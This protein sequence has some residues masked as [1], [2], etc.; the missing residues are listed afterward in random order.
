MTEAEHPFE[1]YE[2]LDYINRK[3]THVLSDDQ[4]LESIKSNINGN[5]S[6]KPLSFGVTEIVNPMQAYYRR[7][8]PQMP[9]DPDVI[10]KLEYGTDIHN[11][12]FY[13]LRYLDGD[14]IREIDID[15]SANGLDG[16]RGRMDFRMGDS[17][18]EFKTTTHTINTEEDVIIQNPHDI[19]QLATYA[20]VTSVPGQEHHLIYFS[21]DLERFF[22]VFSVRITDS[23]ALSS[24]INRRRE[25]LGK[26]LEV[27]SPELLGKCRYLDTGCKFN[28]SGICKCSSAERIGDSHLRNFIAIKRDLEFEEK[29]QIAR[30]NVSPP[31]TPRLS[32][33][34]LFT[35][36]KAYIRKIGE[37]VQKMPESDRN[38]GLSFHEIESAIKRLP[39]YSGSREMMVNG[40]SLGYSWGIKPQV[41]SVP[42]GPEDGFA[43]VITR[44]S[45]KVPQ[46]IN[47]GSISPH[48]LARLGMVC[49]TTGSRNGYVAMGF[50]NNDHDMKFYKVE[51][52]DVDSIRAEIEKRVD[53]ITQA[54]ESD[55]VSRLPKCPDFVRKNC[56]SNCLCTGN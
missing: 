19:E 14:V 29:L 37:Y 45:A 43:P 48:Y 33:W 8:Y 41:S 31:Q 2:W 34:D 30:E 53:E 36:R 12:A 24:A 21:E 55:D 32:L 11:L 7:M 10:Q 56:G 16:I 38:S 25:D 52:E 9:E 6:G 51:F 20:L 1:Y 50:R 15:G 47:T 44:I 46:E 28:L 5:E 22:R 54:F 27:G 18:I 49:A 4:T 23:V 40:T 26:A 42:S 3:I 17:I 35:P 13:W 39:E